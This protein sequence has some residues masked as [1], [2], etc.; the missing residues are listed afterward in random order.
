MPVW[1]SRR[2]ALTAVGLSAATVAMGSVPASGR[3][4]A[5]TPVVHRGRRVTFTFAA[6]AANSVSVTGSWQTPPSP[7]YQP[8]TR[9]R[10][11]VWSATIGPLKPNLYTYNFVVGGL[12][13]RDPVNR[14]G[15]RPGSVLTTFLVPGPGTE[16]LT[17]HDV[18]RGAC[19]GS[20]RDP[21]SWKFGARERAPNL[22]DRGKEGTR[23]RSHPP[24]DASERSIE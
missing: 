15:A 12:R 19:S 4:S 20:A 13:T 24:A 21:R 1:L 6:P 7:T 23:N 2:R 18:P 9:T 11:G 14:S 5:T 10:G 16:F 22:Q 8:L 17:E 3:R